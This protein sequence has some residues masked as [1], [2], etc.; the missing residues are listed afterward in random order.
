MNVA[1]Q[2]ERVRATLL[3]ELKSNTLSDEHELAALK[4]N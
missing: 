4:R 1:L 2:R 3:S